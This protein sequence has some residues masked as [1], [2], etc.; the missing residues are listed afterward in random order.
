M[1]PRTTP[2]PAASSAAALLVLVAFAAP[3]GCSR[4]A[5]EPPAAKAPNP[6]T[7]PLSSAARL[8]GWSDTEQPRAVAP[9][10][11]PGQ[12]RPAIDRQ[13]LAQAIRSA[14]GYLERACDAE[15]QFVYELDLD[16]RLPPSTRYNELRHAGAMYA[17]A[18][19]CQR[20]PRQPT[21]DALR[22]SA[23]F[24]IQRTVGPVPGR[25]G[26]LAVWSEPELTGGQ[27][28]RR[29]K[30]GGTGLGLVAL[31]QSER[32]LPGTVSQEQLQGLA[33]FLRFMQK[34]DGSFHSI[35]SEQRG[36]DD[37]WVSLYYPGEACL[38]L[39]MLY[40]LDPRDEWLR[41]A[42]DGLGYLA[43]PAA[44]D[45][46]A[47]PDH[48]M[49]LAMARLLPLLDRCQPGTR[50]RAELL[51]HARRTC[52]AMVSEQS[53]NRGDPQLEGS[54]GDDGRTAPTATRVEGL[55]AALTF[56]PADD[57]AVRDKIQPAAESGLRFLLRCQVPDG[58]HAGAIP[59]A[60]G[61]L[62]AA[63]PRSERF[64][65]RVRQVRIDYVQHALCA[66]IQYEA[67][68]AER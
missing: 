55:L 61:P 3:A 44:W 41:A 17:L 40:E 23:E 49:L 5:S 63:D 12:P 21:R 60:Q 52:L 20:E 64:N 68:H 1:P 13:Q 15:G 53:P 37:T 28:S 47:L 66:M 57:P 50:S 54:F 39:L 31:V 36:P 56:L 25:E 32:L 58:P 26:L 7:A 11:W 14:T 24:F 42:A 59:M 65:P 46:P 62:P 51:A 22:R 35:Y 18:L 29:A 2:R 8:N 19:A 34:P 43:R 10:A 45:Q 16:G 67:L 6:A 27:G 4:P 9:I 33:R 38:G 30:L 48:W